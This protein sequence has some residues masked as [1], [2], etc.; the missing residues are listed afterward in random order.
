M[1]LPI[2]QSQNV[3]YSGAVLATSTSQLINT[4]TGI[5]LQ[6]GWTTTGAGVL[7][8]AGDEY[9][10]FF[11]MEVYQNDGAALSHQVQF[12]VYKTTKAADNN[13]YSNRGFQ[14]ATGSTYKVHA[15]KFS[16]YAEK[17]DTT[18]GNGNNA[19]AFQMYA[20][21]MTTG[22]LLSSIWAGG[23]RGYGGATVSF[24]SRLGIGG[25]L[26]FDTSGAIGTTAEMFELISAAASSSFS[27]FKDGRMFMLE[28]WMAPAISNG[29]LIGR[30][31]SMLIAGGNTAGG[32]E[33]PSGTGT[34][35][36]VRLDAVLTVGGYNYFL[37]NA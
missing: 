36:Y 8:C 1:S 12:A 10:R 17:N 13:V 21:P 32:F 6:A 16:I 4:I 22:Q 30:P 7:R 11:E 31:Y 25:G 28:N 9:N 33:V 23:H 35:S 14:I 37:R 15:T 34:V 19:W 3:V 26:Y 29:A 27:R 5:M 2:S 20:N 24:A 18:L